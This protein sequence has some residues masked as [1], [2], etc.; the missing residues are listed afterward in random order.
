MP[1]SS[2]PATPPAHGWLRAGGGLFGWLLLRAGAQAVLLLALARW[3]GA[4][5]YGQYVAA[6]AVAGFFTP[7]AGLGLQGVLLRDGA[8]DPARLPALLRAMLRL[9]LASA[10]VCDLLAVLTAVWWLP[11]GIPWPALAALVIAEVGSSSVV[12]LRARAEQARHRTGRYGAMLAGL[13]GARLAGLGVLALL[14]PSADVAAWMWV[15]AGASLAYAALLLLIAEPTTHIETPAPG[16]LLRQGAPFALGACRC[17]CR[18]NS[19]S[20]C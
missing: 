19:T 15:Y 14:L 3:L 8:A 10:L 16:E 11:A 12:E 5:G 7:L 20:R 6:L 17:A 2:E 1:P 13:I 18:R 4:D 9:W